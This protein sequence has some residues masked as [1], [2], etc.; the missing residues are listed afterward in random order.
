MLVGF[1]TPF[2]LKLNVGKNEAMLIMR[3]LRALAREMEYT[4][5]RAPD[6]CYSHIQEIQECRDLAN[7]IRDFIKGITHGTDQ[8]GEI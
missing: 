3:G 2:E 4:D 5:S 6:G 8:Q 7:Q 1:E